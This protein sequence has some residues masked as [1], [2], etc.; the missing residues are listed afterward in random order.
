MQSRQPAAQNCLGEAATS[1]HTIELTAVVPI[2]CALLKP[3]GQAGPPQSVPPENISVSSYLC[4]FSPKLWLKHTCFCDSQML[5]HERSSS[6]RA[7]AKS[8]PHLTWRSLLQT[9]PSAVFLSW[10]AQHYKSSSRKPCI[11]RS[12]RSDLQRCEKSKAVTHSSEE[13]RVKIQ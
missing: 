9:W 8:S 6:H 2:L 7:F 4:V 3:P 1:A 13:A 10:G 5:S 11:W 12:V